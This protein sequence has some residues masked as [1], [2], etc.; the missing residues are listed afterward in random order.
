[1]KNLGGSKTE[2]LHCAQNDKYRLL[3][4]DRY[5]KVQKRFKGT[6]V[7]LLR[8]PT[9]MA[10]PFLDMAIPLPLPDFIGKLAPDTL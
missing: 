10:R 3:M 8:A 1:V 7:S 9:Q 2:I 6:S 4:A 5:Q